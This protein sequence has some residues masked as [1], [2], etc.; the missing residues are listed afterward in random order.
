MKIAVYG[1]VM[2]YQ[3]DAS[4]MILNAEQMIDSFKA[5][6]QS[7][8]SLNGGVGALQS[9]V[10][11]IERRIQIEENKRDS[12][13]EVKNKSEDFLRLAQRIDEKV[14]Q[15][16]NTNKK[17][18]YSVNPWLKPVT[19][20]EEE[21]PWYEKAWDWLCGKGEEIVEGV[22]QAWS[23]IGDTAKKAW[24]GLVDFYEEYKKI[25]DSVL[26]VAGAVLA[27]VAVVATGGVALVPLLGALGVSTTVATA[28][29]ITV[30][31]VAV[32]S[33]VVSSATNII[34][35]WF[36]IDDSRFQT[37]KKVVNVISVVSNVTYSVGNIYNSVKGV[38]G[39]EY[40]ARQKAIKNGE[41]GYS[42]LDIEHPNM[43]HKPGADYDQTRKKA[44]YQENMKRNDGVLRSD[45][46][47]KILDVPQ[48]SAKGV[49]PSKYEAQVDHIFPREAGGA[50]SFS[51]AQVVE[52]NINIHKSNQLNF[53]E[54]FKY[55]KPD[56]VN[57]NNLFKWTSQTTISNYSN[58]AYGGNN[59]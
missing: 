33:T 47:G 8:C 52:R 17:E 41:Q 10:D 16:V 36:E 58:I 51:N 21:E 45:K 44:I 19:S 55:S 15:I 50:N 9:A 26:I 49:V 24:D 57:Y 6:K 42:N 22:K 46:T 30:A 12:A 2:Q 35:V 53:G 5:V 20:V 48:K 40:I 14:S 18:L 28:I 1:N 31:V 56:S 25:I 37:F 39:K 32:V 38:S 7:T 13:I 4:N 27:V 43:K 59:Q 3:T 23:W 54:Y 11:D 34:D 29:S